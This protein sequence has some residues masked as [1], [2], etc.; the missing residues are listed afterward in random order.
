ME[1]FNI[2]YESIILES[3]KERYLSM[4]KN[5]S[6]YTNNKIKQLIGE[7]VD[8]F[9]VLPVK[10][11]GRILALNYLKYVIKYH[12]GDLTGEPLDKL[13]NTTRAFSNIERDTGLN[14]LLHYFSLPIKKIINYNFNFKEHLFKI[15]KIFGSNN[16]PTPY[17]LIEPILHQLKDFEKEW[18]KENDVWID[19]T[20]ELKNKLIE[21]VIDFGDGFAWLDL[22]KPYCQIEGDAMGHCGNRG[23]PRPGDTIYSLRKI[24]KKNNKILSRPSLTFIVNN[25]SLGESKGRANGKPNEK[26]HP[27]ILKLLTTK[28]DDKWIIEN[29]SGGGYA[30]E[31]NFKI[32]DLSDELKQQLFAVRKDLMPIYERFK[33]EG[34]TE[35][36]QEQIVKANTYKLK[37][38]QI[39]KNES[40]VVVKWK[41]KYDTYEDFIIDNDKILK[42]LNAYLPYINGEDFLD[43]DISVS[44][45]ECKDLFNTIINKYPNILKQ[46]QE[47][48][49]SL[50][51][52]DQND[53][54]FTVLNDN[55]DNI[56]D[57]L[58]SAIRSGYESG[59]SNEIHN[60][61]SKTLK[62]LVIDCDNYYIN[63]ES[64]DNTYFYDSKI[65]LEMKLRDF[66]R[67]VDNAENNQ[68]NYIDNGDFD[69]IEPD[70][71]VPYYGF[72][73][74]S[75]EDAIQHF[76]DNFDI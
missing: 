70:L 53:D 30:A 5:E 39:V 44:T 6:Y 47:H 29:I 64:D 45:R 58:E 12:V 52:F 48:I 17:T 18:Q 13:I 32:N 56:I 74:Y 66:L 49:Q 28:I 41:S 23:N 15:S 1:N 51:D 76:I 3:N 75:Q 8:K 43:H 14:H 33:K 9:R 19:I 54:M 46:I 72:S 63:I 16:I 11:S 62:E 73:D 59:T 42:D 25:G 35:E 57:Q 71:N 67:D 34:L 10:D 38:F 2:I 69:K 61:Y 68:N 26:Y 55:N 24:V 60:S 7:V 40:N 22:K 50:Y 31:N 4:F 36:I 27:Y 37:H 21:K 20:N 65:H